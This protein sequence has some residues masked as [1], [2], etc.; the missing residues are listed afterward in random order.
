M[1]RLGLLAA[2]PLP[3]SR[4]RRAA[5]QGHPSSRS[6][7]WCWP[8]CW[9]SCS[10]CCSTGPSSAAGRRF[11]AGSGLCGGGPGSGCGPAPGMRAWPSSCS[12]GAAWPPLSHGRRARPS[13]RWWQR[14]VIPATAYSIRLG[15]AQYCRRVYARMEDQVLILAPQRTGKSG[16]I[17]DRIL[18]HPGA[19]LATSTRPDLY[20]L[21]AAARARRAARST[22]STRRA[23]A[24]CRPLSRGTSWSPAGIS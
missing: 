12:A 4:S 11:G 17:A 16:V 5:L 13:L 7:S 15:R 23:S 8:S 2:G 24:A 19:V 3:G 14:L 20:K 21:T 22:S 9:L 1:R 10:P 6:S 18:S